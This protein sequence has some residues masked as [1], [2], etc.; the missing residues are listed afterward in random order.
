MFWEIYNY[1]AV[2]A[3]VAQLFLIYLAYRNYRYAIKKS[4]RT[5]DEFAP[6][7]LLTVPCKGIDNEFEKNITSLFKLDYDNY[8]LHFVL[9]DTDDE[10]YSKLSELRDKL[11]LQTKALNVSILIAG[12]ADGCSQKIHNLLCSYKN[13]PDDVEI[14]AF[15]DSDACLQ[16]NWLGNL[17]HPLRRDKQ[18]ASTGYRWFI[19]QKN[20][21]ASLALSAIN[22]KV[23]Q[24]LGN[25]SFNQ[26]WG[27][28][29]AIRKEVFER[30]SLDKLWQGAI[31]DDLC[32]S[33]AVK[34][35]G[36]KIVFVPGC[37]VA[38]YENTTWPG[39]LEFARRQFLITRVTIPG[40]WWFGFIS[41]IYALSGIW[42]GS[43]IAIL[44]SWSSQ[45]NI[46]LYIAVP[47]FFFAGQFFRAVLR[48]KM[49]R[50]L[51]QEML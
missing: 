22:A 2:A 43:A 17:V 46:G 10:A 14:L 7:T 42:A 38:S 21:L 27:G 9:E 15:A 8:I 40:T 16:P 35:S 18:G 37:M 19:P 45:Q 39:L 41:T 23:A 3:L 32:L 34:K 6:L 47:V 29:M 11:A 13:V 36:L 44:A 50:K 33:Y 24:L 25:T 20:N 26:A 30:T 31:S 28:S 1:I 5:H 12:Y 4:A 51:F 48:Q 49:I